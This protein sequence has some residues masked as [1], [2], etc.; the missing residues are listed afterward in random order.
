M[1]QLGT[2]GGDKLEAKD[3]FAV[4]VAELSDFH[5]SWFPDYMAAEAVI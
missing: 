3:V 4:S 2:V 5:E 1:T